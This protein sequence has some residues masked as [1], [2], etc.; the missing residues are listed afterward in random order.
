[1]RPHLAMVSRKA[2]PPARAHWHSWHLALRK[3]VSQA[4][5]WSIISLSNLALV[6]PGRSTSCIPRN[7]SQLTE[8][9]SVNSK[10]LYTGGW[11]TP[12]ISSWDSKVM[13]ASLA[14]VQESEES[15]GMGLPRRRIMGQQSHRLP[16]RSI[17]LPKLPIL[18]YTR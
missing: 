4:G 15:T 1:M 16:L 17:P 7:P 11:K 10:H 5:L 6:Q 14:L 18:K 3:S 12:H 9:G 8:N 13:S 2:G